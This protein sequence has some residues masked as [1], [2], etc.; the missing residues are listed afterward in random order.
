MLADPKGKQSNRKTH[1]ALPQYLICLCTHEM[2]YCGICQAAGS[3]LDHVVRTIFPNSLFPTQFSANIFVYVCVQ[4]VRELRFR[5]IDI[6]CDVCD[7]IVTTRKNKYCGI[8]SFG[9]NKIP[10][11]CYCLTQYIIMFFSCGSSCCHGS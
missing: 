10:C 1:N 3:P 9:Y 8:L 4:T 11:K 6:I 2:Y 7:S 5:L